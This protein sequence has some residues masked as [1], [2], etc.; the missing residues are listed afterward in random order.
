MIFISAN[1]VIEIHDLV[2]SPN[3]L[4]GLAKIKLVDPLFRVGK[5]NLLDQRTAYC[6]G[7]PEGKINLD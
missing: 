6:N 1:D 7:I 3:V 4:H 2:I 5:I